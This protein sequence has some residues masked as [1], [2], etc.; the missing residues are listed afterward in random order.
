[1]MS[2]RRFPVL[3][4]LLVTVMA[5]VG[6]TVT[7]MA[8]TAIL[9]EGEA[10]DLTDVAKIGEDPDASGGAYI[11]I[12]E[13]TNTRDPQVEASGTFSVNAD[14]TY[15]VWVRLYGPSP[16]EDAMY[17]TV[18]DDVW[19]RCYPSQQGDYEWVMVGNFKLSAG[20][21]T[22]KVGHGEINCRVDALFITND[23]ALTL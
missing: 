10:L 15:Y 23:L 7:A 17:V 8:Q 22:L 12:G 9:I 3:W 11:Y 2:L 13:G 4:C 21:H 14:G 16:D 19:V 1:M 5:F 6:L 20:E 18:D